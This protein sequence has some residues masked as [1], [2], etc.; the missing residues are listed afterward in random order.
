METARM[1]FT[2]PAEN[3]NPFWND[4]LAMVTGIDSASFA[5]REDRNTFLTGGGVISWVPLT[6]TLTWSESIYLLSPITGGR[7]DIAAGSATILDGQIMYVSATRYST[8]NYTATPIVASTIPSD[9]NAVIIVTRYGDKLSWRNGFGPADSGSLVLTQDIVDSLTA[10]SL[11][12]AANAFLTTSAGT[13][14]VN[15]SMVTHLAQPNPHPQYLTSNSVDSV[16]GDVGAVVLDFADVGA[17]A[18]GT[19]SGLMT[20]HTTTYNH[21]N[22]DSHL[23]STS[24]PHS[25][26]KSQLGI[27]STTNIVLPATTT[28][29]ATNQLLTDGDGNT[30]IAKYAGT[31]VGFEVDASSKFHHSFGNTTQDLYTVYDGPRLICSFRNYWRHFSTLTLQC[32]VSMTNFADAAYVRGGIYIAGYAF[33]HVTNYVSAVLE[34][35]GALRFVRGIQTTLG[36][37]AAP[38]G[39]VDISGDLT[40]YDCCY[41][42]LIL[43]DDGVA[44]FRFG[45]DGL[46]W[47]DGLATYFLP[48][49]MPSMIWIG[50]GHGTNATT[51]THVYI[52]QISVIPA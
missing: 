4:F 39:V 10:A 34:S 28:I 42:Q 1:K 13:T 50:S 17:D 52:D 15:T 21:G 48:G 14:L 18:T 20:T 8:T 22:Y 38:F 43:S 7:G 31:H 49:F 37:A 6:N 19:A 27:L 40:Y 5:A 2:Y 46:A 29:S 12:S 30:W 24:N 26:T 11:P 3:S 44:S 33:N 51:T 45:K 32:R 36:V 25:V 47:V 9:N 16:N 35:N 23:S 41:I